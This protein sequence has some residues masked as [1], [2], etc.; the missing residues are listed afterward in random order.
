MAIHRN[1]DKPDAVRE[2]GRL[3]LGYAEGADDVS[4]RQW[5]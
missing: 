2:I 5:A 4:R 1:W 3:G